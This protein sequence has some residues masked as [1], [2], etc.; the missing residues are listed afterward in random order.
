MRFYHFSLLVTAALLSSCNATAAVS[1]EGQVITSADVPI[2][3]GALEA[4]NDTR[5]SRFIDTEEDDETDRNDQ[6]KDNYDEEERIWTAAQ[7]VR[8]TEKADEWIAN[9]R[10]P[11]YVQDKLTDLN[12][13]MSD[14]NLEKLRLFME[15][16]FQANPGALGRR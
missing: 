16:W 15:K 9:G 6:K 13:F 3:V 2:P 4:N 7:I 12:G 8:W 10:T 11:A 14:K 1:V 5:S